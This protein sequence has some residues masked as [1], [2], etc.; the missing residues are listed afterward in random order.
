VFL[1]N[2]GVGFSL[3]PGAPDELRAGARPPHTLAPLLAT[4][5]TGR[6]TAVLGTMGGDSQPQVLLQLLARLRGGSSAAAALEAPRWA[7]AGSEGTGFDTWDGPPGGPSRQVVR[8]EE[9]AAF[10]DGL[11]ARGHIVSVEPR[12]GGFG[13]AHIAQPTTDGL[14]AAAEPRALTG[15]AVLL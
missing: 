3:T 13:H 14:D 9:G 2:R 4:D 12:G 8:V 7:L 6:L 5:A 1:Q 11:R 10:A 15:A